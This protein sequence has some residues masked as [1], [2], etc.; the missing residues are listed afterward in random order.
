MTLLDTLPTDSVLRRHA[1]TER[2]RQLGWPPTDSVLRRHHA[3][4]LAML[5]GQT[6]APAPAAVV[7]TTAAAAKPASPTP[8]VAPAAPATP[9]APAAVMRAAAPVVA[10]AQAS[11][12]A[13]TGG[14]WGWLKRLF[15]G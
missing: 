9:A 6:A 7:K 10:A 12:P 11:A 1:L 3:Q 4:W 5:A 14:L 15:G 13:A 8:V 2:Q